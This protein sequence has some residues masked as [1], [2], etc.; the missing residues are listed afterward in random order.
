MTP[1]DSPASAR[2]ALRK[3]AGNLWFSWLPGARALFE[4]LD[5]TR[6]AALDHNPTALVDALTDDE[7]ADA[8]TPAYR[9]RLERVLAATDAER[10]RET[11]WTRRHEDDRFNVAYFSS[12][13]GLD[14]SLPIY[15]G[16]LGV[17]AGDHLKSASDLG[18]PLVA[19]GLFYREGYFRQQLDATGWQVERYPE[20]NPA[21]L[22]LELEQARVV[23]ELA[24]DEGALVPV[25]VQ[26]WRADVGRVPLYLLDTDVDGN[27]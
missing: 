16:G 18:V 19:V 8:L 9:E 25:R 15:S 4:A 5:P 11:W 21:R 7:L 14:E 1:I 6:F 27:P 2:D 12:E 24:D 23:V 20:N 22:P 17:L 10:E 3:L 13:F 26:V